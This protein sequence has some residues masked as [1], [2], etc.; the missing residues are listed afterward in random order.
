ML[1]QPSSC[2]PCCNSVLALSGF[3]FSDCVP[4]GPVKEGLYP[5]ISDGT[6]WFVGITVPCQ[7]LFAIAVL[8]IARAN[9]S[10]HVDAIER[11]DQ[12]IHCVI[13]NPQLSVSGGN[14]T[15][16]YRCQNLQQVRLSYQPGRFDMPGKR[17]QPVDRK[18]RLTF[19][20]CGNVS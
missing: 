11:F 18:G 15:A 2:N 6:I 8:S 4:S 9:A 16:F 10:S 1:D 13:I 5:G 12:V 19:C 7:T 17:P 20:S 3:P 14:P